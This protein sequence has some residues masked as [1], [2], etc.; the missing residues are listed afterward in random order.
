MARPAALSPDRMSQLRC[1]AQ[2]PTADTHLQILGHADVAPRDRFILSRLNATLREANRALE[3]YSFGAL[4]QAIY[5]FWLYDL[6]DVY[7]EL[8][9]VGW[10]VGCLTWV[11]S[12]SW[13]GGF[14]LVAVSVVSTPRS[15]VLQSAI[16]FSVCCTVS[17][18]V[19]G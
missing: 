8:I 4:T 5:S 15:P 10:R 18:G 3:E 6:C 17:P 9:K 11:W 2:V 14:R 7:L 1:V 16:V 19:P 12:E 13:G